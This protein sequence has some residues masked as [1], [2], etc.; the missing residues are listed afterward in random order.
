MPLDQAKQ[1]ILRELGEIPVRAVNGVVRWDEEAERV[2]LRLVDGPRPGGQAVPLDAG[3]REWVRGDPPAGEAP[4]GRPV[5]FETCGLEFDRAAGWHADRARDWVDQH[6][7]VRDL[8]RTVFLDRPYRQASPLAEFV[9]D[10]AFDRAPLVA[11]ADGPA[12]VEF[13]PVPPVEPERRRGPSE[14]GRPGTN[15]GA[16]LADQLSRARGGAGLELDLT[17]FRQADR[18]PAEVRPGLPKTG[19]VNYLEA[20]A[21]VRV[22]ARLA[23]EAAASDCQ[24]PRVAVLALYE[25]QAALIR[26]LAGTL[27]RA[28]AVTV[29]AALRQSEADVVVVSLT[30]SHTHRAVPYGEG[31]ADLSLAISRVR[32]R[33]ILVGDPGTLARRAQWEGP[34]DHLDAGA[35]EQERELV[36]RLVGYLQ[37]RG[38]VPRSFR[39]REGAGP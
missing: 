7:G 26:R 28:P 23:A 38:R 36:A 29:P 31:P 37:G 9:A 1:Y 24:L 19:Y 8:G 6:L 18:L 33:L 22:L 15:P 17:D 35:A 16:A 34:L 5:A 32:R 3:V 4:A 30:R 20:Q 21:V 13:V 27:P 12:V 25:A 39:L 10:V 11:P 2:V 14:R